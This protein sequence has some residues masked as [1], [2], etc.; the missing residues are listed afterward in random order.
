MTNSAHIAF[1]RHLA[2]LDAVVE[3][4]PEND[5]HA[6]NTEQLEHFIRQIGPERI[7]LIIASTPN[8]PFGSMDDIRVISQIAARELI[9]LHVDACLGAYVIQ[10]VKMPYTLNLE[11]AIFAGVT[12]WSAD[13][14]KYGLAKKGLS[15]L[16]LKS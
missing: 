13:L 11:D 9:P 12:S 8:Y 1:D 16:G 15:F 14:H 10:F 6:M 2:D 4:V 7:A 5:S 3:R